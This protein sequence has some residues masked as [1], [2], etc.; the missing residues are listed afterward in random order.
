LAVKVFG[1][2]LLLLGLLL[3]GGGLI[4]AVT[5]QLLPNEECTLADQYRAEA[6]K[7]SKD[8]AAETDPAKKV[9]LQEESLEK[10]QSARI[11]AEGCRSRK[12][13]TT[14]ALIAGILFTG[15]GFVMVL[16]GVFMMLR[17]RAAT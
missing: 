1:V 4:G 7:L 9:E 2:I 14:V 6:E 17:K 10:M 8:A 13:L 3:I 12:T 11:W 16:I 15:F 5:S